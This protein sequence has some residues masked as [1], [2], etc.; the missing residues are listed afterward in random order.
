[1]KNI[2]HIK[3]I[4]W[5]ICLTIILAVFIFSISGFLF[6][7][8]DYYHAD[9]TAMAIM[10]EDQE[11][12]IVNNFTI[13]S[14]D[15]ESNVGFIFYP[16]AKVEAIAYLPIL[17]EIETKCDITCILVEMPLNLAIFNQNAADDVMKKFTEIKKWYIGGHSLGGAMASNYASKHPDKIEGLILMGAYVYGD[18]PPEKALT[19]YGSFN[20][21]VEENID[22]TDN[23]IK[24]EG[25]N[26]AQFGNY[27][28]Q[29]GDIDATITAQE[30]QNITVEAIVDFI[31]D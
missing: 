28:K 25:G 18:Y 7:A 20:L 29:K 30:Q 6:W 17:K 8:S 21:D 1:L 15:E 23:I 12:E 5:K 26:H 10:Q 13:L 2:K 19:V 11:I 22:Y 31:K 27:G 4:K 9:E 14:P 24:I 3:H 16:G